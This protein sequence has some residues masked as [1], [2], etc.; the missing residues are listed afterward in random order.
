MADYVMPGNKTATFKLW[1]NHGTVLAKVSA[2]VANESP[3]N[4]R[5]YY[6]LMTANGLSEV[7]EHREPG[8]IFYI[9]DDPGIRQQLSKK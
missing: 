6:R 9:S 2:T 8:P 3:D 4:A 1:N 7:I 5:P